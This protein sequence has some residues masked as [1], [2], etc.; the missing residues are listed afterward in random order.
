MN[1]TKFIIADPIS[2][3][4]DNIV[5]HKS[6]EKKLP[7][8]P[9]VK[10]FRIAIKSKD[11]DREKDLLVVLDQCYCFGISTKFGLAMG[12][13]LE[14]R[15]GPTE[16]QTATIKMFD[17][18]AEKAKDFVVAHKGELNKPKITR[19]KLD[20]I[21][22]VKYRVLS[23][24]DIDTSKPPTMNVKL[25][26]LMNDKEGNK[27][28]RPK[29]ISEFAYESDESPAD[30]Y[31]FIDKPFYVRAVVRVEG[32]F[33]GAQIKLQV[34]LHECFVTPAE[35]GPR[36]ILKELKAANKLGT[37]QLDTMQDMAEEEEEVVVAPV[38]HVSHVSHNGGDRKLL[39][40]DNEEAE[41]EE[42]TEELPPSPPKAKKSE[43][44]GKK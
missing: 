21:G 6:E 29:I 42:E 25:P 35:T 16:L 36:S 22:V 15:E 39:Q 1:S 20:E 14:D 8:D 44:R 3:D 10:Y 18:I 37:K 23:N 26:V 40:S 12:I 41:A 28:D 7:N 19:E 38:S 4:V 17:A 30:P 31:D 27:L 5:F 34:K 2:Y 13:S 24:G 32:I 9:T 11:G 43:R 33:V